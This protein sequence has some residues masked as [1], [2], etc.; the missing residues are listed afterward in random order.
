MHKSTRVALDSLGCKLNQAETEL[1]ARQLAEAGYELVPSV[2]R[3][4]IYILNTCTVTHIADRKSRHLLRLAHRQNPDARL[5]A[6]GC[7]VERSPQ[8]LTQIDGV[9]LVLGNEEKSSLLR[10]LQESGFLS[11][12]LSVQAGCHYNGCRHRAFIKVQD[13]CHSL[14]TYCIVPLVRKR[15]ESMP[16]DQVVAEIRR[17]V[18]E[19]AREVVL[20]GTKIGSYH[21]NGVSLGGLLKSI[22]AETEVNRLRLSSLQPQEISPELL[23]L[24]RDSRLC[25]HFHLSL[26]SGSDT[27]LG[28][29]KRR[30]TRADYQRAVSLIREA[31]PE[32]AITTDVIVG[33]PGETEA[34][35]LESYNL[36]RQMAFTRIH[37]FPYSPR[38]ETEAARM[39]H[40]II[41]KIKRQRSQKMLA[42]AEESAHKFHQRFLGKTI[43][44]LWEK[45]S[46]GTWS[47]F[48]ANYIKVYT[49]SSED[50][51]NKLVPVKL[52][53]IS[54]D[55]VRGTIQ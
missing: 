26:Q 6:I 54:K 46:D 30:Y 29:M 38:Q 18:T 50:L 27:V 3:A 25:P 37:V 45:Q 55:V 52:V 20:T 32:A 10:R 28:R 51:T 11:P 49:E 41:D 13:G 12:P 5:V 47:G 24:W 44:V 1:F 39:P 21:D 34:E 53:E 36:C 8:E 14:C 31:V 35:F 19:G 2:E 48:T 23:G 7:Y 17:R 22:L 15:E 33:F 16:V 42:L 43:P 4:D 9:D 40:Q